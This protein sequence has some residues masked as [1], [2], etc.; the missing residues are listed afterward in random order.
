[1]RDG[2]DVFVR[3]QISRISR[4]SHNSRELLHKP[5][6]VHLLGVTLTKLVAVEGGGGKKG[7]GWRI[8]STS[9]SH[10]SS[11]NTLSCVSLVAREHA[12]LLAV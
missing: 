3:F 11:S 2:C 9:Q 12:V 10:F 4:A 7:G 5:A 8:N 6:S 1:M